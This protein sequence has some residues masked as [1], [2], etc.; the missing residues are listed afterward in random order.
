MEGT[1]WPKEKELQERTSYFVFKTGGFCFAGSLLFFCEQS[2]L[3]RKRIRLEK[4]DP[5]RLD[6]AAIPNIDPTRRHCGRLPRRDSV[7]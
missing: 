3:L 4:P 5:I 6:M 2:L 7:P 1:P